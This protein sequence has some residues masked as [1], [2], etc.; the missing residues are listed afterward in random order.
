ME[1]KNCKRCGRLFNELSGEEI[2][3]VCRKTSEDEFVKVKEYVLENKGRNKNGLPKS[4]DVTKKIYLYDSE[5]NVQEYMGYNEL[6]M[7]I[8]SLRSSCLAFYV[9]IKYKDHNINS[10][11]ILKKIANNLGKELKDVYYEL[12]PSNKK[13]DETKEIY[14]IEQKK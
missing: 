2:C 10:S 5:L 14:K 9:Y 11:D 8:N 1:V 4:K 7:Q 6:E 13:S 12:F 3:P